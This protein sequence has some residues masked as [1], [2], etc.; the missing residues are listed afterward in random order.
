MCVVFERHNKANPP[1]QCYCCVMH[2][3]AGRKGLHYL[4]SH[5]P[6]SGPVAC[7]SNTLMYDF[8]YAYCC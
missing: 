3:T 7:E 4:P 8:L 2:G 1:L 5:E 6:R